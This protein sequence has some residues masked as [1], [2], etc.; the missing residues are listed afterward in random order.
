MNTEII[1][2]QYCIDMYYT[3]KKVAVIN[4]GKVE[5][6]VSENENIHSSR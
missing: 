2:I 6:F 3:K 5:G 4:N 1:T